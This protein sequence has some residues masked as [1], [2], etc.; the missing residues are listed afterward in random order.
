MR[1]LSSEKSTALLE[2]ARMTPVDQAGR[3]LTEI[4]G[5]D[6]AVFVV[7]FAG[8]SGVDVDRWFES[9]DPADEFVRLRV[10]GV[11]VAVSLLSDRYDDA[12]AKS[13]LFGVNSDLGERSP[14]DVIRE[15]EDRDVMCRVITAA[16][17]SVEN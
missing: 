9:V 17:K 6:I 13:W 11:W 3:R 14:A 7:G 12:T 16:R 15:L 5:G 10:Y 2:T 8:P 1:E 4:V